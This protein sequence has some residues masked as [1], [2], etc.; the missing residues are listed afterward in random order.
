MK[1]GLRVNSRKGQARDMAAI[2]E[3]RLKTLGVET[4]VYKDNFTEDSP[5]KTDIDLLVV[6]GGDGTLLHAARYFSRQGIPILGVNFG[7]VGFLTELEV[8]EL[9]HYLD[10]L[11]SRDFWVEERMM[12][13]VRLL[14]DGEVILEDYVL[15]EALIRSIDY[16][17]TVAIFVD[18]LNY[19]Y[20]RGDGVICCT[21]SGSTA[22]SLSAGGP[23]LEPPLEAM[24]IT[25]VN[26]MFQHCRPL[27]VGSQR[28][29]KLIPINLKQMSL[30]LDG[31]HTRELHKG[32]LVT[33]TRAMM[34]T[35]LIRFK[36]GRFFNIL[37]AKTGRLGWDMG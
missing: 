27:V 21:A 2:V 8:E 25:P 36:P 30:L 19:A 37:Q 23:L 34:P 18:E 11:V 31:V 9:D 26:S 12:L 10:R 33:I 35:Q 15:N 32:D 17:A 5:I 13:Q 28:T 20:C 24:V 22:Y 16:V 6:M 29:I 7:K 4:T 3:K 1:I 14:R